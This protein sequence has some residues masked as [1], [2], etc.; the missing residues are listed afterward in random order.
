MYSVA[1]HVKIS[2]GGYRSPLHPRSR[3]KVRVPALT[4]RHTSPIGT[5]LLSSPSS[6]C[7]WSSKTHKKWVGRYPQH[8]HLCCIYSAGTTSSPVCRSPPRVKVIGNAL[9]HPLR[10]RQQNSPSANHSSRR[11]NS[12]TGTVGNAKPKKITALSPLSP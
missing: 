11:G 5:A 1:F 8:F 2:R 10:Q 7:N 4:P 12:F 9:S 6:P 3:I